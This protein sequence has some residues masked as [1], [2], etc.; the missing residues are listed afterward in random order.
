MG[1]CSFILEFVNLLRNSSWKIQE[2]LSGS[3]TKEGGV[4]IAEMQRILIFMTN[5][6]F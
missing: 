6:T 5:I 2:A 3:V 4:H 1:F